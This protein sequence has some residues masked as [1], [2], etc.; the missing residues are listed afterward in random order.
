MV[1]IRGVNVFPSALEEIL[2]SFDD[3]VEYRI[4]AFQDGEMDGLSVEVEDRL[5]NPQ[6]IKDAIEVG[7]GL[8]V[9]VILAETN[10]LP[11]FEAKGRRFIDNR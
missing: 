2:R 9:Q 3:V 7:L 1:V 8:R 11:R 6:R 5:D 4:T 10:S